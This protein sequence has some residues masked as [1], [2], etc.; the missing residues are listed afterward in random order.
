ML[1]QSYA[2]EKSEVTKYTVNGTN[3]LDKLTISEKEAGYYDSI[4]LMVVETDKPRPLL[5]QKLPFGSAG[6]KIGLQINL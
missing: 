2:P 4:T 3:S 1:N 6:L 5:K